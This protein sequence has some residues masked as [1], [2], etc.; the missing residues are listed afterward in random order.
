MGIFST[1]VQNPNGLHNGTSE[2]VRVIM[3]GGAGEKGQI[4]RFDFGA[5]DGD[6]NLGFNNA[7][8]DAPARN[9]LAAT[10]DHAAGY[11]L[12]VLEED[13]ADDAEGVAVIRGRVQ[14]QGNGSIAPGTNFRV[15]V[16][17]SSRAIPAAPAA[18]AVGV[19]VLAI[20]READGAAGTLFWADFNGVEKLGHISPADDV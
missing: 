13:I 2:R 16:G 14:I 11:I 19:D 3:R 1:G 5:S 12:A 7:E 9:V 17:A 10:G 4:V 6:V 8:A 18:G 20:A 15:T